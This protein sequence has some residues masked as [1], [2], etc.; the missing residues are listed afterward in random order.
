M[1]AKTTTNP[2]F[3]A[4]R[5]HTLLVD[6][7]ARRERI[8]RDPRSVDL[9]TWN[10]FSSLETHSDPDWLAFRMQ[11]LAGPNVTAPVRLSLWTGRV[12]EPF[13]HQNRAYL[14]LV[15][16]RA[17]KVGGDERSVAAFAQ[18][19]EVPVRLE[20]ADVVGFVET[21][22]DT[23]P[24]G[25]GG[26]DRIVELVDVGL[27]QARR[28]SARLAVALVYRSGTPVGAELAAR[29]Q[30]LQ[31]PAVLAAALPH[32]PSLPAVT[33]RELSWQSLLRIWES[34]ISYLRLGG[35]PVKPFLEHARRLGLR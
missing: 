12:R 14:D 8:L 4:E 28:L 2:A 32:R 7:P 19:V 22:L 3:Y 18:P 11:D 6:E 23:V 10:I 26:R 34:E 16:R 24:G 15:Q 17:R 33:L 1:R 27:D 20:S 13:L 5:L 30:R 21:T 29:L 25:A 31:D 35:Q 9:L